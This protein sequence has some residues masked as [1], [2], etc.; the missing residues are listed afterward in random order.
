VKGLFYEPA[1]NKPRRAACNAEKS[2]AET[3]RSS[4]GY[5]IQFFGEACS[6]AYYAAFHAISAVLAHHGLS[7]SSHAQTLAA[8][9]REFVKTAVFPAD[10]FRKLQRLFEDRQLADYDWTREVDKQTAQKDLDDAQW[11][12][13]ACAKYLEKTLGQPL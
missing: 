7:F 12:V 13:D 11:L 4:Q 6:R 5:G 2:P 1:P 10:T 8:F 9:N 3:D